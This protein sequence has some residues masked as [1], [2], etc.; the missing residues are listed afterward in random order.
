MIW[1]N[2]QDL[3][4]Q[5]GEAQVY[6][7]AASALGRSEVTKVSGLAAKAAALRKALAGKRL[8]IGLDNVEQHLPL[9]N[10][11][12]TLTARDAG[13]IGPVVL[14]TTR[15]SFSGELSALR[16]I[17]L[18]VLDIDTG[19]DLL[20]ALLDRAG[21]PLAVEDA[22]VARAIVEAIGALPLAIEL[23]APRIAR[24]AE[25]IAALATRLRSDGGVQLRTSSRGIERTFDDTYSQL[26]PDQQQAFSALTVFS[27]P[28]FSQEAALVAIHA[29]L[30]HDADPQLL[31]DLSDLSLLRELPQAEG[32]PRYQLHP[33][34]RQFARERLR[35]RGPEIMYRVELAAARHYRSVAQHASARRGGYS[36]P[37]LEREYANIAGALTWAHEQM[38]RDPQGEQG[39][40]GMQLVGDLCGALRFYL[41]DQGYW[42]DARR[43]L[44]WGIAADR[45]LGNHRREA[46]LLVA[47]AFIIRQQ[48]DLDT[49][50]RYYG[51]ALNLSRAHGERQAEAARLQ[52][53]GT[54]ALMRQQY[55]RART[56]YEE[57][58]ALRRK[59]GDKGGTSSVL[60]AL[61]TLAAEQGQ[62]EEARQY[63][64]EALDLFQGRSRDLAFSRT[65]RELAA[66]YIRDPQGDHARARQILEEALETQRRR[67][68]LYDIAQTLEW[69]GTLEVLEQ[70][71]L[72]ARAHWEEALAIYQRLGSNA[73]IQ[74]R[75]RLARLLGAREAVASH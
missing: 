24:R 73:A 13:D 33:L 72:E 15:Y 19:L 58:L 69:L 34:L 66:V 71:P 60:R 39:R 74:V 16:E 1:L 20:R 52:N 63:L 47:V 67:N 6:E 2:G 53:L 61:G 57:S 10:V 7:A 29:A 56:L 70:H 31:L 44:E 37:A 22:S 9:A 8:L 55:D 54:V 36:Q 50:E 14:M 59:L 17:D 26:N 65:L 5:D 40:E 68:Q 51:A 48:G 25:P 43:F 27:G 46:T 64:R 12:K 35:E 32:P 45:Q 4:A 30:G 11:V 23:V 38:L 75:E 41:S 42:T 62:L 21:R 49:A 18:E 28:D 3:A